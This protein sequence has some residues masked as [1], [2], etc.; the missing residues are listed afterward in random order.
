MPAHEL[1]S[2][3]S[4]RPCTC[5]GAEMARYVPRMEVGQ[6]RDLVRHGLLGSLEERWGC[7][8]ASMRNLSGIGAALFALSPAIALGY[9]E[10]DNGYPSK[11]ER[12]ILV[13]INRVR[14]EPNNVA[15][16]NSADCST[17]HDPL[18]PVAYDTNLSRA[19]RFHCQHL[20]LNGGGLSHSSFCTLTA[21][22]GTNGCD[23]LAACSCEPSTECWTCETLGG[24]GTD[25]STRAALFG[26]AGGVGEVGAANYGATGASTGWATECPPYE[27]HRDQLTSAGVAIVGTGFASGGTCWG[28]YEFAEF[29]GGG[30][31]PRI[32]SAADFGGV[33]EANYYDAAGDPITI[34]AVIDGVCT[35]M[36]INVGTVAGNRDYTAAYTPTGACQEFYLVAK[37][38]G[39]VVTRYPTTGSLTINCPEDYI[40]TQ[41]DA[42]CSACN[43]GETR[44]CTS[45]PCEGTQS[46]AEGEWGACDAPASCGEGGAGTGGDGAGASTAGGASAGGSGADDGGADE[47]DGCGCRTGGSGGRTAWAGGA[48]LLATAVALRRRRRGRPS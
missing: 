19:A 47:G 40:A 39:G 23:G 18:P 2:T 30:P 1:R 21:D 31:P 13:T 45:G 46:C 44:A 6:E 8:L 22:V 42:A 4:P 5:S 16:G 24:C 14:A 20:T 27:G 10:P 35:P 34:D 26:H 41:I 3:R 15:A 28:D 29:A 36:S 25:P 17:P 43:P 9:G 12:Q 11:E 33:I 32:A 7:I 37:D 48:L 38:V